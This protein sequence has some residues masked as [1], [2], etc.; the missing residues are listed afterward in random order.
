MQNL[1]L[2]SQLQEGK[3]IVLR[4][5]IIVLLFERESGMLQAC[6]IPDGETKTIEEERVTHDLTVNIY[7]KTEKEFDAL[8]LATHESFNRKFEYVREVP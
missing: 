1:T 4:R 7:L 5:G 8:F 3:Q 6:I 2:P